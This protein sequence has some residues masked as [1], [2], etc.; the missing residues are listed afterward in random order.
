MSVLILETNQLKQ[1][2]RNPKLNVIILSKENTEFCLGIIKLVIF[3][4]GDTRYQGRVDIIHT[5]LICTIFIVTQD[6][7][8]MDAQLPDSYRS[9]HGLYSLMGPNHTQ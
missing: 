6:V 5:A 7:S 1:G 8:D 4:G 2:I 9:V 3:I